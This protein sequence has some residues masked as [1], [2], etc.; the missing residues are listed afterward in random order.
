M[1]PKSASGA[2]WEGEISLGN[3]PGG[4][5]EVHH[6]FFFGSGGLRERFGSP[7]GGQNKDLML[8]SL[9]FSPP[10]GSGERF[11]SHFGSILARFWSVFWSD[12]EVNLRLR[13]GLFSLLF[14][15]VCFGFFGLLVSLRP[16]I[17]PRLL[18]DRAGKPR[19]NRRKTRGKRSQL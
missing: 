5:P 17:F 10:G 2:P 18:R 11:W 9:F 15:L 7:P 12:F 3:S 13:W 19:E 14:F 1:E 8:R 6:E 16:V 4:P